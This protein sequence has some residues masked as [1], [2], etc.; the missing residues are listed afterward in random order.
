MDYK[1]DIGD[2]V[3]VGPDGSTPQTIRNRCEAGH[4]GGSFKPWYELPTGWHLETDLLPYKG[5]AFDVGDP[6]FI[7]DDNAVHLIQARYPGVGEGDPTYVI[8]GE[9]YPESRVGRIDLSGKPLRLELTVPTNGL[10]EEEALARVDEFMERIREIMA[11][12]GISEESFKLEK[13]EYRNDG[14]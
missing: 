14:I 1:Y 12:A 5:F 8:D 11:A 7:D 3:I 9:T 10:T 13:V 6:V 2:E 4:K